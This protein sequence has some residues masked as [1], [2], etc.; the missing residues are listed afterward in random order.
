M[1]LGLLKNHLRNLKEWIGAPGHLDLFAERFDASIIGNE[2]AGNFRQRRGRSRSAIAFR[3]PA[4]CSIVAIL[5]SGSSRS[6]ASAASVTQTRTATGDITPR[7]SPR[8]L[9]TAAMGTVAPSLSPF[10]ALGPAGVLR[11]LVLWLF[12]PGG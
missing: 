6:R 11:V 1:T 7:A 4:P 2:S 8:R 3:W 9:I 10:V 12:R 5:A